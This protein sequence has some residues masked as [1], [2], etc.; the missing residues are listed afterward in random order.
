MFQITGL[1][2][3]A[4]SPGSE[5]VPAKREDS[6]VIHRVDMQCGHLNL[7]CNT[8]TFD[9]TLARIWSRA[10]ATSRVSAGMIGG[11]LPDLTAT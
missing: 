3:S 4:G 8:Y 7:A 1:R 5:K 2:G 11:S 10:R 6:W 9:D